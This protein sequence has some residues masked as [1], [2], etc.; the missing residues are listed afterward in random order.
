MG[1]ARLFEAVVHVFPVEQTG[2]LV[3]KGVKILK[4]QV[5]EHKDHNGRTGA[6]GDQ[7]FGDVHASSSFRDGFHRADNTACGRSNSV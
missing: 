1:F 6:I 7:N 4:L 5:D 3:Y 2:Q